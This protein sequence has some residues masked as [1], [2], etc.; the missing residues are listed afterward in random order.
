MLKALHCKNRT[1]IFEEVGKTMAWGWGGGFALL[2]SSM[3]GGEFGQA[4]DVS[5]PCREAGIHSYA[6]HNT[7]LKSHLELKYTIL[8][9]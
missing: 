5:H 4:N 6:W 2:P 3:Q 7:Y 8:K 1:L 9:S